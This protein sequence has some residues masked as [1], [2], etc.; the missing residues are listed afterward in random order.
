MR[1]WT[2][3]FRST[4]RPEAEIVCGLLEAYEINAVVMDARPSAY[5]HLG[6]CEVHVERDD[7]VRALYLVRKHQEP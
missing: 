7:V 4:S 3:V 1:N 5:P 2:V 6:E